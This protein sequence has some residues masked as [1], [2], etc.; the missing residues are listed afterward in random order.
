[1]HLF[2]EVALIHGCSPSS[3]VKEV[4]KKSEEIVNKMMWCKNVYRITEQKSVILPGF[5]A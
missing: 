5:Q 1:M 3:L 2:N 4:K